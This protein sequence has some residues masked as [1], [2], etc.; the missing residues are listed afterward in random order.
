MSVNLDLHHRSR[1]PAPLA[2]LE[3][4]KPITWFPPVW[5][6]ACGVVSAGVWTPGDAGLV[7]LGLLLAGPVI[8]GMSQAVNDWCDRHVDAL[9]EP[10]RP[11]PSG[12]VSPA[13]ALTMGIVMSILGLLLAWTLGAWVFAA[14]CVAVAGAWAYSAPPIRLKRDGWWGPMLVALCY[15]GLPW[16]TGAAA[17]LG[18]A[19]G[20]H[21]ILAA[22]LYAIGAQGIMV[23]NDFKAIEGDRAMG[24]RSLPAVKGPDVAARLACTVMI[25]PQAILVVMLLV[26][27]RPFAAATIGALI[28][29]QAVLMRRFLAR[30][31]ERATWYSGFGVP[32]YVAGMM[33]TAFAIRGLGVA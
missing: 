28:L 33:V 26:W 10:G 19:P 20:F 7:L 25:L 15:E 23:L 8:C 31:V 24:I 21:I 30:P 6:F 18:A 13:A 2:L 4:V 32:I 9:N 5:A 1:L 12:R 11:I 27:G 29:A 16:F 22:L 3:L 17:M 14:T